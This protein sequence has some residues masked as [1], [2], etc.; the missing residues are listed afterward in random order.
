MWMFFRAKMNLFLILWKRKMERLC[1]WSKSSCFRR[2]PSIW[3]LGIVFLLA[4]KWH[5][6]FD[7]F[8]QNNWN[9]KWNNIWTI[10]FFLLFLKFLLQYSLRKR[11]LPTDSQD[12]DRWQKFATKYGKILRFFFSVVISRATIDKAGL[13]R[14]RDRKRPQRGN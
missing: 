5:L 11:K 10:A 1:M 8:S 6:L 7:I 9:N 2:R 4:E 14:M 13:S 12:W 3:R